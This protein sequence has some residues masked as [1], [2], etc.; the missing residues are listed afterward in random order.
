MGAAQALL[1]GRPRTRG[2]LR[3]SLPAELFPVAQV[4]IR[5]DFHKPLVW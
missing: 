4:F 1:T 2:E 3:L 5:N